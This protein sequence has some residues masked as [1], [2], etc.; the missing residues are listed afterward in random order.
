MFLKV[1]ML[2]KFN[3]VV[4]KR[5]SITDFPLVLSTSPSPPTMLQLTEGSLANLLQKA[6]Q[7]RFQ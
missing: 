4:D 1:I 6:T 7:R 3:E 2:K 5:Q